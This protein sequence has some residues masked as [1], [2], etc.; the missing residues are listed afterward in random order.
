MPSLR[1]G[2]VIGLIVQFALLV[3]LASTTGLGSVGWLAGIG[4]G[5]ALCLLVDRA[6][7]TARRNGFGPADR[8]TLSRALLVGCVTALV[9]DSFAREIAVPVLV[10]VTVVALVLDAVDGRVAR[11]TGTDSAFGAR[12]DMEVD[13][14]LILVL[15]VYAA[16]RFGLWVLAIGAMRYVYV[17]ATWVLPWL[18]G[19]LFP[20]YWRKVVAAV[21]GIVLCAASADLLPRSLVVIALGA[22]LALLTESFGRDVVYLFRHRATTRA[23][24]PVAAAPEAGGRVGDQSERVRA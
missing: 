16:P 5:I 22:A 19:R 8:V 13:A 9:V 21:Q 1:P 3:V 17:V 11:G 20:R 4:Y 6:L 2:P 10:G 18:N 23:L 14:F 7:R 15:S 12:F 24:A